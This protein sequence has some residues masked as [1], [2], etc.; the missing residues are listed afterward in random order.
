VA[1]YSRIVGTGSYLPEKVVT[2]AALED[3]VDTTDA[4]I[5]ERTGIE[6]RHIVEEGEYTVD[7]A[8]K[9]SR[10]AMDAAGVSAS[11]FVAKSA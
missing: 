2:N 10:H 5:R 11:L 4:W 8:E 3:M 6:Q 9:A 7:L 1:T